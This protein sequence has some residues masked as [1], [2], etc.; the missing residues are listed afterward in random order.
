MKFEHGDMYNEEDYPNVEEVRRMYRMRLSV[1]EVPEHDFRCNISQAIAEDLKT[2]YEQQTREIVDNVLHTQKTRITDILQRISKGRE[3]QEAI[4]DKGE[5]VYK[6]GKIYESQ[7]KRC[8]K[9]SKN[10]N[11]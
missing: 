2:N 8:V 3:V 11:L 9:T 7:H 4:N 5:V 1:A 6:K 10:S